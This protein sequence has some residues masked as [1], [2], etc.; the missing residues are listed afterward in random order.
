MPEENISIKKCYE[1]HPPKNN[2]I[3]T[4][5][6]VGADLPTL[7]FSGMLQETTILFTM[8]L[9][10]QG[11]TWYNIIGGANMLIRNELSKIKGFK[12]HI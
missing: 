5:K 6:K 9:T 4:S 8:A 12:Q 1:I 3:K 7:F 11:R 2:R 10:V